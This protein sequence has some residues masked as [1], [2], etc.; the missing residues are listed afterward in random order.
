MRR[1]HRYLVREL[2]FPPYSGVLRLLS[3]KKSNA[4]HGFDKI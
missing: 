3:I 2:V 1:M 4:V